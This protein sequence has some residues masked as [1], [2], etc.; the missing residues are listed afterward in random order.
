M[1]N[2]GTSGSSLHTLARLDIKIAHL[3]S[4]EIEQEHDIEKVRAK[5]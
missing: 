1:P 5:L 4:V 2:N 3:H